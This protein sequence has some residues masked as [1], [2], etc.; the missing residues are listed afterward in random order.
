MS[1]WAPN[2]E[3]FIQIV[4][5]L[6]CANHPTD[7][8]IKAQAVSVKKIILTLKMLMQKNALG[9]D[10]SIFYINVSLLTI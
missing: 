4:N 9:Y 3:T 10:V 5:I 2:P 7:N 8:N 1:D 6:E